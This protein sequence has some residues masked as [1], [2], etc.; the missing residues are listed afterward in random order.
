MVQTIVF[1]TEL[2][3]VILA[4]I[5]L[6]HIGHTYTTSRRRSDQAIEIISAVVCCVLIVARLSGWWSI[7]IQ[8]EPANFFAQRAWTL[9]D[10]LVMVMILIRTYRSSI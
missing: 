8:G 3:P 10:T 9:F 5:A 4:V 7:F 6:L 2:I 1:Y